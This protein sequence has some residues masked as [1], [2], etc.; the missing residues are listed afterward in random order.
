MQ[1]S[2]DANRELLDADALC[3]HLVA[4]GSVEDFL[5]DHRSELFPDDM[6]ADLFPT[7]RGRPS[8]PADV[9]AAVMVL[10]SLE[11]LSDR[12][13]A[14]QL[15]TNIAWKV[16]TDSRWPIRASTPRCSPCGATSCGR[17]THPSASLTRC[18][19]W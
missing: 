2:S 17:V 14:A 4:K 1:G 8:V 19:P 18:A 5:A 6:F 12:D 9:V 15:R 16:A 10:Q 7:R 13:A 3:R 11:G